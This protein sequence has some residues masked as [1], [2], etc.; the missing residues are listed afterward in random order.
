MGDLGSYVSI[1]NQATNPKQPSEQPV[2]VVVFWRNHDDGSS[3]IQSLSRRVRSG[4]SSS[5][6]SSTLEGSEKRMGML[7]GRDGEDLNYKFWDSTRFIP[8]SFTGDFRQTKRA[9]KA[10]L[11]DVTTGPA[12]PNPE[13]DHWIHL[14]PPSS[15]PPLRRLSVGVVGGSR[16]LVSRSLTDALSLGHASV[17]A[18]NINFCCH[19]KLVASSNLVLLWSYIRPLLTSTIFIQ[20]SKCLDLNFSIKV[21]FVS[22]GSDARRRSSLSLSPRGSIHWVSHEACC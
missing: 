16:V 12:T 8:A 18:V 3:W 17:V 13:G 7:K 11:D 22:R 14:Y 5:T 2:C 19:M 15:V 4:N 9:E 1:G 20:L 21:E 10:E 6:F